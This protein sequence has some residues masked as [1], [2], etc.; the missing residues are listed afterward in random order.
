MEGSTAEREKWT[1]TR[2][3]LEVFLNHLHEDREQAGQAYE[4]I[5]RKLVT[6][7]RC[8]GCSC[9][10]DL[11]DETIDRVIRRLGEIEVNNLMSFTRGVAR[12]VASELHK[13]DREIPLADVPEPSHWGIQGEEDQ[14]ERER[15]LECLRKSLLLLNPHDRELLRAWYLYEKGHKIENRKRLAVARGTSDGALRVQAFRARQRLQELVES[16]LKVSS[17][18]V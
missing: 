17:G 3:R 4:Q 13:K 7:F 12:H 8:N 10:E 2:D 1:L 6:F 18:S 16:C 5:R 9:A 14:Q 11:V 15:S